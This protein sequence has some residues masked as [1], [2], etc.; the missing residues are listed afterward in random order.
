M[1]LVNH[2]HM[3]LDQTIDSLILD[4]FPVMPSSGSWPFTMTS[5]ERNELIGLKM[6][7]TVFASSQLLVLKRTDFNGGDL[8]DYAMKSKEYQ[9]IPAQL[10]LE[11]LD[12]YNNLAENEQTLQDW[13]DRITS[14][15][16]GLVI[17]TALNKGLQL[18][19]IDTDHSILDKHMG[20]ENKELATFQLFDIYNLDPSFLAADY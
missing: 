6:E 10:R 15:A 20:F 11:F 19:P 5:I 18:V 13:T 17:K 8:I 3:K 9:T 2:H 1:R 12:K 4:I 7:K 16:I 14:M